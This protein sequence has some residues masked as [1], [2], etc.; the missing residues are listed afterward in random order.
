MGTPLDNPVWHALTG[1]H[2]R[3]AVGRGQAR[4]YYLREMA[5][6]SGIADAS[7]AAYADLAVDL[8]PQTEARLFRPAD[9][10]A[11]PGW[12]TVSAR[13][14]V[15]MIYDG[16]RLPPPNIS[17]AKIVMLG[18]TDVSE[19]LALAD[20]AKPGPFGSGTIDLGTYVG[21]R[22]ARTGQLIAMGGERFRI[23]GYVELSAIAVHPD[24][25]GRGLGKAITN[26]LAHAAITRSETPFLHVFPDNPAL[27]LYDRLGF[28]ERARLWVL[29]RRPVSRWC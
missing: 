3:F 14:I 13:P 5:P 18:P 2:A 10:P 6:F 28:C 17:D 4:H 25:R 12:E 26:H 20:A 27:A 23:D 1:R 8:P 15:Q 7:P 16:R 11:P 24:A 22:Q 21:V 19:M 29:W 9:E